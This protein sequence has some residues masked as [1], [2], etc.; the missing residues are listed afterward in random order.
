MN[1]NSLEDTPTTS[2]ESITSN[3]E[4]FANITEFLTP[5]VLQPAQQDPPQLLFTTE[6]T[7]NAEILQALVSGTSTDDLF[8]HL[9]D[10]NYTQAPTS[11]FNT[12]NI[13][14]QA[15][16]PPLPAFTLTDSTP[17]LAVGGDKIT[18]SSSEDHLLHPYHTS[19][20]LDLLGLDLSTPTVTHSRRVSDTFNPDSPTNSSIRTPLTPYQRE[21]FFRWL[22]KNADDPKPKGKEREELRRI[23]NMSRERFKTWFANARRRYFDVEYR[24]G[25]PTYTVNERFLDACQRAN[26]HFD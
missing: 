8:A 24:D 3:M 2:R 21:V 14:Y 13:S 19:P 12:S 15:M 18:R 6:E 11:L 4:S 26:I 20:T 5:S 7:T 23:G 17:Q 10:Q 9:M 22:Y 1:R 25:V 16:A